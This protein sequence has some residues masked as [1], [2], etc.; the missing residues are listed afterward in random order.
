MANI[1]IP[2]NPQESVTSQ[3]LQAMQLANEEHARRVQQAQQ[4]QAQAADIPYK[5]ALTSE[6]NQRI[7]EGKT[8]QELMKRQL[9]YVFGGSSTD[10]QQGSSLASDTAQ[11]KQ[12]LNL[13]QNEST[14]FDA[15][16]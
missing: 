14:L 13:D 7:E 12:Q 6:A 9:Q 11:L 15:A 3:I 1:N 10:G 8:K 2:F 16:V 4:Q 5:Q